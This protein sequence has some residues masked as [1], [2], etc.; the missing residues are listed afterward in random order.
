M[1]SLG[2]C[3]G[4]DDDCDGNSDEGFL[5]G[6]TRDG[7]GACGVGTVQCD[8]RDGARLATVCSTEPGGSQNQALPN[9]A[10][11]NRADDDCDGRVDQDRG[12]GQACDGVGESG[13]EVVECATLNTTRCSTDAC[14]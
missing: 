4:L 7:R 8:P 9:D 13:A 10:L 3:N 1:A 14:P 6:Q 5:L 2:S 11:C 12:V